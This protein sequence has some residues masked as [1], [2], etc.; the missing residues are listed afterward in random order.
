MKIH[1]IGCSGSGK[2]Y[3][4]SA[5]SQKYH[6]PHFDLDDLQWD[7]NAGAY[8]VKRPPEERDAMLQ[9]LLPLDDWIIE[10]VY[11]AWVGQC[12]E[13]ADIIYILDMP[14]YLYQFRILRRSLR[15]RLGLEA[16]KRETLKSVLALLKWTDTFQK[17]NLV[18]ITA[19]LEKYGSKVH[20]LSSRK[21]VQ[22]LLQ[23]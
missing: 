7:N 19:I 20:R 10:G 23:P 8:G 4:A 2:T 11:Y 15:R 12:F 21:A 13:M 5:L 18:E 1:I 14:K 16:G 6:I 9:E 17:R 3:L 22:S